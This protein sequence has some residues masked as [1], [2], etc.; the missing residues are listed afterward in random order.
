MLAKTS[1]SDT[2]SEPEASW[3][4]DAIS[5][6]VESLNDRTIDREPGAPE[7][8]ASWAGDQAVLHEGKDLKLFAHLTAEAILDCVFGPFKQLSV[9]GWAVI[10]R[11]GR[12][13]SKDIVRTMTIR[14]IRRQTLSLRIVARS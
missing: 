11:D 13:S 10:Q 4:F 2:V 3:N 6:S 8:F 14:Q 9:P 12:D 5:G 7:W 1:G